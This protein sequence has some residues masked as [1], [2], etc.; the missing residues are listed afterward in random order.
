M[1]KPAIATAILDF[2]PLNLF[3]NVS[4][5]TS[6]PPDSYKN[7]PSI[8]P[9]PII[10]PML[11]SVLPNPFP[12]TFEISETGIRTI[13]PVPIVVTSN[14]IKALT[15]NLIIVISKIAIAIRKITIYHPPV[16]I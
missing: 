12:I 1:I 8:T 4:A 11:P 13:R 16:T 2:E 5:M 7:L 15:L 14:A 6:I 10:T 3:R 9:R